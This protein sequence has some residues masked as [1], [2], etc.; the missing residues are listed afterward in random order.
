MVRKNAQY[1]TSQCSILFITYC[2]L[3]LKVGNV[4]IQHI[5]QYT[6]SQVPVPVPFKLTIIMF[7]TILPSLNVVLLEGSK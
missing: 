7:F 2:Q 4:K 5:L 1:S 6:N 3:N